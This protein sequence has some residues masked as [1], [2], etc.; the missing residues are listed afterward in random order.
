MEYF[1]LQIMIQLSHHNEQLKIYLEQVFRGDSEFVT[2]DA[3]CLDSIDIVLRQCIGI[4]DMKEA[5][6]FFTGQKLAKLLFN[7]FEEP[8]NFDSIVIDPTCGA[9]NLLIE[10]SRQLG[11]EKTLMSTL[12]K[13]GSVLHGYDI[14]ESF[15]EAAKLRI[16]IEA[17]NR[18]VIQDGSLNE[19]FDLL[20]NI[21]VRDVMTLNENDLQ[22]VTHIVMNPPFSAWVAPKAS[23]WKKGKVNAAG[24]VFEHIIINAPNSVSI[25]S[26]LPDV[27]RAGT[28][29]SKW[30]NFISAFLDGHY[31]I[32][33]KFNSKTDVDVF[34]IYGKVNRNG[35]GK[36]KWFFDVVENL[37]LSD[38]FDVRVGS[39]VA[40]RD[41][42]IG[43]LYPF[44]SPYNAP[45][46][47]TVKEISIHRNFSGKVF[48][49]PFIVIRRTSSP[50]DK[51]RA[52][53]T[54]IDG[55]ECVAVENH[56]IVVQPKD[57][58]KMTCVKLLN[59]LRNDKVN[60]YLNNTIR[61]RHLTVSAVG[62]IPIIHGF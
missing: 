23:N 30:R 60:D 51:Y 24:I 13:W 42:M 8:I 9:G 1:R 39:L 46:W 6:S 52:I 5:G 35:S 19:A 20:S 4:D 34:L 10:C 48:K 18:G 21:C 41:P 47:G 49:P 37:T 28:S 3:I 57:G 36:F 29:Y 31:Q 43:N 54:F 7:K 22:N 2:E 62:Q 17:L 58:D 45:A 50:S 27:L 44:I 12:C 40:Y 38:Y 53:G 55:T 61:L 59:Y 25:V 56:L 14:H 32:Y 33:G 15:V 11:V 16:I 26:V